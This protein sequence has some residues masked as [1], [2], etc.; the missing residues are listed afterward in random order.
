MLANSLD[1]SAGIHRYK[2]LI[3]K[4]PARRDAPVRNTGLTPEMQRYFHTQEGVI[5]LQIGTSGFQCQP[6]GTQSWSATMILQDCTVK[7]WPALWVKVVCGG[8][9]FGSRSSVIFDL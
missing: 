7:A 8:R 9:H 6:D 1:L 3:S 2:L 4:I 5:K